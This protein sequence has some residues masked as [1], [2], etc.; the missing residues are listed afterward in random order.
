VGVAWDE[1]T[2]NMLALTILYTIGVL[3]VWILK[4]IQIDKEQVYKS[5]RLKKNASLQLCKIEKKKVCKCAKLKKC[6]FTKLNFKNYQ[7]EWPF[8]ATVS[9]LVPRCPNLG[10]RLHRKYNLLEKIVYHKM[11]SL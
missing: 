1:A 5:A 2:I 10:M 9:S 6:K 7:M 8:W 3:G 11:I 4:S